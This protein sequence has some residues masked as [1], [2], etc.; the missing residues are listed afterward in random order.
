M[1]K[2]TWL[3][4]RYH[5]PNLEGEPVRRDTNNKRTEAFKAKAKRRLYQ[6]GVSNVS[7]NEHQPVAS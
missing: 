3:C 5:T 6:L 7:L 1:K 4:G 2:R